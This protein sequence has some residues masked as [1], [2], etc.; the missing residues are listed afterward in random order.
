[1]HFL[2]LP[3][4]RDL[5]TLESCKIQFSELPFSLI[6]AP[7]AMVQ[8]LGFEL[9]AVCDNSSGLIIWTSL[10]SSYISLPIPHLHGDVCPASQTYIHSQ[11]LDFPPQT[12]PEYSPSQ[13][14]ATPPS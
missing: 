14:P 1:M 2:V 7:S 6:L 13:Y 11:T 5:K 9:C 12:T 8:F 3:H 10:L 4:L